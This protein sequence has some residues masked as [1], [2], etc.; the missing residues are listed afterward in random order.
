MRTSLCG[1][2]FEY[3]RCCLAS[4]MKR[5]KGDPVPGDITGHPVPGGYKYGDMA[6]HVGEVSNLRQ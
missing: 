2:R 4:H 3:L 1:D 5:Q 6:V